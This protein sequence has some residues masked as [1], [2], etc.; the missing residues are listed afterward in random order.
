MRLFRDE[1]DLTPLWGL[2]QE[3]R[4]IPAGVIE[5]DYWVTQ[6]L[7]GLMTTYPDEFIFKGGTSLSKAYALIERFSEDIDILVRER[8][9]ES[10]AKCYKRVRAMTDEAAK[11]VGGSDRTRTRVSADNAG[12]HRTELLWYGPQSEGPALMLPNIRID[13]GIAG[14]IKPHEK[15]PIDTLLG[16]VLAERQGLDIT[17]YDDLSPFYVP[18]LHPGRTLVEKMLLV[19]TAAIRGG[20]SLDALRE[21]RAGR[22]YYDIYC[23][24]EHGETCRLLDDRGKFKAV[25]TDAIAISTDHFDGVEPRPPDGFAASEAFTAD[26]PLREMLAA[27]YVTAMDA[28]YFGAEQYPGFDAICSRVSGS[29]DLL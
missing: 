5:K 23:L 24:L 18:V 1:E 12:R 14:G 3:S 25:L 4:G 10:A 13:I 16:R 26:D 22:H 29:R 9:N 2:A 7:R 28:F 20:Q 19:H 27:E 17:G 15:Q 8:P 11:A 21:F 6:A